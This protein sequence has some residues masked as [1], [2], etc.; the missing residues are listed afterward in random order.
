[1]NPYKKN[2]SQCLDNKKNNLRERTKP[3]LGMRFFSIVERVTSDTN[4]SIIQDIPSYAFEKFIDLHGYL[5]PPTYSNWLK[6]NFCQFTIF[7]SFSVPKL[8]GPILGDK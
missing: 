6:T 2:L 7:S 1:L 3:M 5:W 4:R 8:L